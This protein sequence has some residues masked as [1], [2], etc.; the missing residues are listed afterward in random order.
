MSMYNANIKSWIVS[1]VFHRSNMRTEFRLPENTT[2]TSNLRL[3][4]VGVLTNI[5]NTTLRYNYLAGS[6]ACI[7]NI[8]L[9]DGKVLLDQVLN[10]PALEGF[11]RYNKS[12]STN[13]DIGKIVHNNGM[14]FV[15]DREAEI[16][17]VQPKALIREFYPTAPNMPSNTEQN[18]PTAFINLR[19]V[20]PLLNALLFL[21]T[22][23]FPKLSVII[24]YTSVNVLLPDTNIRMA[25]TIQP[26]LVC[27]EIL[28]ASNVPKFTGVSW[29]TMEL[30]T[31][32]MPT[33]TDGSH[34]VINRKLM[35]F[36]EKTLN[37][38]LV[39]KSLYTIDVANSIGSGFYLSLGSEAQVEE[40]FQVILNGGNLI[41]DSGIT[42]PAMALSLLTDTFG[43]CNAI[44]T[45]ADVGMY[46][47]Q[48][49]IDGQFN[50]VGHL[51]YYGVQVMEKI[52]NLQINYSRN[53][54][55]GGSDQYKSQMM[56]NFFGEVTKSIVLVK[57]GYKVMYL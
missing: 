53:C 10:F 21:D 41:A 4:N 35:G 45:G 49:Y 36:N 54:R 47:S 43:T 56:L 57:D 44:P 7:K 32:E 8:Y 11:K 14:G 19:E 16:A 25:Q 27:D 12:N 40:I 46:N 39:Q 13:C 42:T 24:E 30:E 5:N 6:G 38:L 15:Y 33:G 52:R 51:G 20:F 22:K 28:D 26:L 48:T 31:V 1:P 17:N 55:T 50:R 3:L 2:L 9:M 18:T 37:R 34:Q 23:L 29:N